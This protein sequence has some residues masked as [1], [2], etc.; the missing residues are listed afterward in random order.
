MQIVQRAILLNHGTV[1]ASCAKYQHEEIDLILNGIWC[2]LDTVSYDV[3]VS[4]I[5]RPAISPLGRQTSHGWQLGT[6]VSNCFI[7]RPAGSWH[8]ILF[9]PALFW[10][11]IK[12]YCDM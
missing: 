11:K 7:I 1:T 3:P 12:L 9:V 5:L 4:D 8:N 2:N 10:V 6:S